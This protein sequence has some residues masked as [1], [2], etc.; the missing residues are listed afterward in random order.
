MNAKDI[1][2]VRQ[3]VRY[4]LNKV[5]GTTN[6]TNMATSNQHPAGYQH[7][8]YQVSVVTYPSNNTNNGFM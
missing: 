4:L 7:T 8:V 5:Y 1:V 3:I 2:I 6:T